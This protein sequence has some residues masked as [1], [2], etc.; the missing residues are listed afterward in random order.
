MLT[1][2]GGNNQLQWGTN[3]DSPNELFIKTSNHIMIILS[4]ETNGLTKL[5]WLVGSERFL[6]ALNNRGLARA[7]LSLMW[8]H[9]CDRMRIG[10]QKPWHH[11][12]SITFF[13]HQCG[14][15][16]KSHYVC[17]LITHDYIKN[18]DFVK[19]NVEQ[20]AYSNQYHSNILRVTCPYYNCNPT[21]IVYY[22]ME[23]I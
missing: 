3:Q 5:G 22:I 14:F 4:N 2:T 15:P 20:C 11:Q 18:Y 6:I 17:F 19:I 7:A 12:R 21:F 23:N 8:V 1:F 10:K 9:N 13:H 16:Y